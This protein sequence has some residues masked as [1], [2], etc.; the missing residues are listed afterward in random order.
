VNLLPPVAHGAK[1]AVSHDG[2]ILS[3][4]R[5][6]DPILPLF[7]D[8]LP[9]GEEQA[10]RAIQESQPSSLDGASAPTPRLRLAERDQI[11]MRLASL[12]Q[13]LPPDDPVRVVWAMVQG[14]DV[15]PL[16]SKIRAVAGTA[17][18]DATDPRILLS[19]WLYATAEGV[20]SARLLNVL[21]QKHLAYEWLC[22]GVSMNYHTLADFRVLHGE[23]LNRLITECVGTMLHEGLIDL[24]RVAQDGMRVR[25][26]A[27]ASSFRRKPSLEKCLQEAEAQVKALK[28]Q[29]EE[30]AGAATRRQAAAQ[31]RAAEERVER[32]EKALEEQAQMVELRAEQHRTKGVKND[33]DNIRASTTDPEARRMKFP[34]GG[35]RPGFNVQF[36]TTT[37]GGV[38]VGVDV[39]NVGSDNGQMLPMV[40]QIEKR[41]GRSPEEMLNDGGFT[42]LSDIEKVEQ[43]HGTKVYAPVKNAE[44]QQKVGKNPYQ[45]H[46]KDGPGVAQW[47]QRMGTE[48]AK[49]IYRLRAQTAEWVNAGARNRGLYQ[50]RVRGLQKTKC[51]ALW[52]ALT[53]NL[54][55]LAALRSRK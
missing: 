34:D 20:G 11:E 18:R 28:N 44:K 6:M 45:A 40:E 31:K 4:G 39:T 29:V 21:C 15:S 8:S 24:K 12:D 25:A 14:L 36:A 19:L 46:K 49:T 27:G 48:E 43:E 38:I 16:L 30:D 23:F 1:T 55:R 50:V 42:T 13:L 54:L 52:H 35:T 26:N 22:G 32:I 47:R 9:T 51:I 17:G 2:T 5:T 3:Q 33:P 37:E 10:P 7:E 41:Y 53:H